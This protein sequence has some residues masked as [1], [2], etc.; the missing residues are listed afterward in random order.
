MTLFLI[1]LFCA[2]LFRWCSGL[3]GQ[4]EEEKPNPG[5]E[6]FPHPVCTSHWPTQGGW[7]QE[8][9]MVVGVMTSCGQIVW[10]QKTIQTENVCRMKVSM[11]ALMS[12]TDGQIK[13]QSRST[14]ANVLRFNKQFCSL[15]R[16]KVC[17][18]ISNIVFR[19]LLC[20]IPATEFF[21]FQTKK[22]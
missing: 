18:V 3:Q 7:T 15:L 6:V 10:S 12:R 21:F 19:V 4:R 14:I 22:K 11:F 9:R 16:M 8:E 13:W 5:T 20:L 17:E 1:D 2:V